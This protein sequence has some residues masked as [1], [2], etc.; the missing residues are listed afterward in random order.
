VP[1]A[2]YGL[3]RSVARKLVDTERLA[4][5]FDLG[6]LAA[7]FARVV[8]DDIPAHADTV[9]LHADAPGAL[10][11]IVLDA[12]LDA[13][14][15]RRRFALAHALGHVLLGW[16]PLGDACDVAHAP[17]E[18]PVTVHDLVEGEASAFARELLL[19]AAWIASFNAFEQPAELMRHVGER[20]GVP[21]PAAARAVALQL[22]PGYVWM[23][24]DQWQ[25]V[26]DSGRAPGTSVRPPSAGSEFDG[27]S[28]ARH[29]KER[30]RVDLPGCQLTV[31]RFAPDAVD[32]L[33][34]DHS[35][36]EIAA[37]I[38]DD[39]GY[40]EAATSEL[41]AR[42]EGI[43][44]WANEQPGTASLPGMARTLDDRARGMRELDDVA[45]HADYPELLSAKATELVTKRIAR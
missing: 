27:R 22:P 4:P 10:P 35:A 13:S 21:L 24:A 41:I 30:Q 19:P 40:G 31:W 32:H 33:P 11:V 14:P 1:D 38:A 28:Y 42:I 18:L 23:V 20:G 12:S 25:R 29:A 36:R 34:H 15:S 5:P 8:D 44:G 39:L 9:V 26:Q 37:H 6:R 17:H 3:A 7:R 45:A 43:A 2:A 16:H